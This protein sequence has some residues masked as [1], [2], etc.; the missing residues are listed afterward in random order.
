MWRAPNR[1]D[2]RISQT[3][4]DG[5]LSVYGVTADAA[6]PGRKPVMDLTLKV[7]LGF[8][9]RRLGVQRYYQAAQ[10][11]SRVDRVLRVPKPS[12]VEIAPQDR[13][14]VIGSAVPYR[15]ELVQT[16]PDVYPES[17][18]LSLSRVEPGT[19]LLTT[20]GGGNDGG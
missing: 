8:D 7:T 13:V 20:E 5:L 3:Y 1:P 14:T 18:D 15:V 6:E 10:A 4:A 16:V 19:P 17:L 11:L 12:G 9:E 2:N